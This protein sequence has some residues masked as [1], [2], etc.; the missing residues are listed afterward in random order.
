MSAAAIGDWR[1]LA[2]CAS[3]KYSPEL[4]FPGPGRETSQGE[5]AKA[6]CLFDCPVRNQCL[7]EALSHGVDRQH[8]IW[9]GTTERQRR[10]VLHRRAR[11]E[12]AANAA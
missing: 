12:A 11:A 2:E 4:W 9:G 8:G 10:K 1:E 7:A 6:I 3:G 5:V